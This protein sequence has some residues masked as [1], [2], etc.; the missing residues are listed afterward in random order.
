MAVSR[1]ILA[2]LEE[3][4]ESE[5]DIVFS[6]SQIRRTVIREGMKQ[7]IRTQQSDVRPKQTA[8]TTST[9]HGQPGPR[10]TT[11]VIRYPKKVDYIALRMTRNQLSLK[12]YGMSR[13]NLARLSRAMV[14]S[15]DK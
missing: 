11:E 5:D 2:L 8:I 15:Q 10:G 9:E 13:H 1:S 3:T 14:K 7:E 6:H 12:E 4:T